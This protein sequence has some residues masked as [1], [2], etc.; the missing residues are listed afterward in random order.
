MILPHRIAPFSLALLLLASAGATAQESA[1]PLFIDRVDVNIVNVEVWVTDDQ[2][3]RVQG[4]GKDDFELLEDGVPVEI[5]N[6]YSTARKQPYLETLED[7]P[8]SPAQEAP[9]S[10][11]I[12][13]EQRLH[14]LVM[15]DH[16]NSMPENRNRALDDLEPF[17]EDR[18]RQGD[19]VMLIGYN[20]S[21]K[22]VEPFTRD[23]ET[24]RSGL[25]EL[26]RAP[27]QKPMREAE[28]RRRIR[29]MVTAWQ[30]GEAESAYGEVRSQVQQEEQELRQTAKA[31][32]TVLRS[33]AGMPGRKAILYLSDGLPKRPGRGSISST[34]T[35][36]GGLPEGEILSSRPCVRTRRRSSPASPGRP[37]LNR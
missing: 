25:Q 15:V 30:L 10:A 29:G 9:P 19:Q 2:G 33:L 20:Q 31:F 17:L 27:S 22:V 18:L 37:M 34:R 1:E 12:P 4:L 32:E 3:R 26:R 35:C 23:Q 11:E 21:V 24:I 16:F 7:A 6:F 13:P 14:L 28:R 36:L 8:T 5:T